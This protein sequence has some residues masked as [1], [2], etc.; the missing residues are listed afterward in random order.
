M[1]NINKLM[2]SL[3]IKP[4]P[5]RNNQ[6]KKPPRHWL[7]FNAHYP[8]VFIISKKNTGKTTI[9]YNILKKSLQPQE[10]TVIIFCPNVK[11][12]QGYKGITDFIERKGN[13]MLVFTSIVDEYKQNNLELLLKELEDETTDSDE[14]DSEDEEPQVERP[15]R[16]GVIIESKEE[17]KERKKVYKYD[18]PKYIFIFDDISTE[19]RNPFVEKLLKANRHHKA[20]TIISSQY[21]TDIRLSAWKQCDVALLLKSHNKQK[22]NKIYT[23][24]DLNLNDYGNRDGQ[25]NFYLLYKHATEEPYSFLYVDRNSDDFRKNFNQHYNL[26]KFF[27]LNLGDESEGD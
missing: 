20:M 3:E 21:D 17:K 2:K 16:S 9:I 1:L 11:K 15:Q 14:E 6:I 7:L 12:D 26:D 27:S 25:Y 8:N 13:Q 23:A 5:T 4:I 22:L 18:F 24:L 10:T 19:L